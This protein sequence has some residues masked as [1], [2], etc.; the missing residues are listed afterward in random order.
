MTVVGLAAIAD[1]GKEHPG[2]S[3]GGASIDVELVA[4][5]ADGRRVI[6]GLR[7]FTSWTRY[8]GG[9]PEGAPLPPRDAW[10][11]KTPESIE[12]GVRNVLRPDDDDDPEPLPWAWIVRELRARGVAATAEELQAVPFDVALSARLRARVAR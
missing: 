1:E 6:V 5:L 2:D 7:G 8:Y 11:S 9:E 4:L 3:P 10:A 12:E